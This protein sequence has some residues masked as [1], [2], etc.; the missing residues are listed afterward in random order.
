MAKVGNA[1][2]ITNSL[3]LSFNRLAMK[4]KIDKNLNVVAAAKVAPVDPETVAVELCARF[5]DSG[6]IEDL[7]DNFGVTVIQLTGDKLVSDVCAGLSTFLFGECRAIH[8]DVF[9]AFCHL[10]ILGD[11]DCPDCGGTMELIEERGH[12][13]SNGY[14][15]PPDF[16]VEEQEY[17][18]PVCGKTIIKHIEK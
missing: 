3:N 4:F 11:G 13:K 7:T 5:I 18:C 1:A 2:L 17:R 8:C 14:Y 6:M 12:E 15:I 10:V 16:I 9:D